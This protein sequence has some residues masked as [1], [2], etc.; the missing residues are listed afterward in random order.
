MELDVLGSG[1]HILAQRTVNVLHATILHLHHLEVSLNAVV[2]VDAAS[3]NR[4]RL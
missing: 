4:H 1:R 2:I 3:K